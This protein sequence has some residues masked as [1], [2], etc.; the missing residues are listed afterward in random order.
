MTRAP[1]TKR[2]RSSNEWIAPVVVALITLAV[3]LP[4]LRNG[5]V[6]WD[7]DKN[8]LNNP[9]Y[10]GLGP[11]QLGWMWTTFR[12]GHYVPLSWMT[13]GLDYTF[14]TMQ[15]IGYHLTNVVL[16]AANA[17]LVYF[18]A[19]RLIERGDREA[20]DQR[21]ATA[22]AVFAALVFSLHPLR[23]ESVAWVTERRDVL[24]LFFMLTSTLAYMRMTDAA[25]Q[26]ARWYVASL[27]LA[28]CALLSK[29]TAMTLPAVLLI[30]DV[31]PLKRLGHVTGWWTPSAKRVYA[32]LVPFAVC[33]V[34][35]IALS[36]VALHPPQQLLLGQKLA[37][38]AFGLAFYLWKT[39][40]PLGLAP[41]YQMPRS[42]A[43]GSAP[44]VASY[45]VVAM[46][47]G[48]AW[49]AR[50]RRPAVTAALIA[51][52][53]IVLPMLGVVQNGPQI[54]AD[55]YTYHAA[56][57]LAILAGAAVVQFARWNARVVAGACVVMLGAMSALTWRQIAVWH[58]SA[59]LW[60]RVLEVD[61]N[62]SIAHS[63]W[64]SLLF[65]EG[66]LDEA[67]EH[68]ARA[69]E[70]D[71]DDPQARNALGTAFA[72]R[73]KLDE[74][75]QQFQRAITIAPSS[76]EVENNWGVVSVQQSDIADA[77]EH[78]RRALAI[79]VDNAD[80]HVNWGNALVRED[81][82]DEAISHYRDA[83][84]IRPDHA[85]AHQ[86]WGVALARGGHFV[87]AI[88]QFRQVLALNPDHAE[89]KQYLARATQL[90]RGGS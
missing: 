40:V 48:A 70:L 67:T 39:M 26:R 32:E 9:H 31:Y 50:Q 41:L 85:E 79:N 76:D 10:R 7:D 89:A 37:I 72:R 56:P 46:L 12:L 36:I 11:A 69:V 3:F 15:P 60:S 88:E 14:W 90:L 78:Y 83:L 81:K 59:T 47:F 54:A 2:N 34:A 35:A 42:L 8:F 5:F 86:N 53:V 87:E 84:A 38:S 82:L 74:A 4:A 27:A 51:F 63:S 20:L 23:V 6:A 16:H 17:T 25:A 45:I 21:L 57:A 1:S 77:I 61:P 13:L 44:F 33:S 30:L 18:L 43:L 19:R 75:V 66:R 62:S 22:A 28:I 64:A 68:S 80:A 24:S 49:R 58:D 73:G 52:T 29:A 71:P 55:R 65:A